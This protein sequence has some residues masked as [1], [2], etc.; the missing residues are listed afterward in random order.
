MSTSDENLRLSW[1]EPARDWVE[2]MP[3]GNGRIGAMV[4]G[5]AG[6][7]RIRV[8]DSTVWSGRPGDPARALDA[9][10]AAGAGPERLDAVRSAIDAEDYRE[11][12]ALL[13]SFEGP[14]SQ[15]FLPFVDL[16]LSLSSAGEGSSY[17]R[18]L[19][20]L[21]DAVVEE[22]FTV[23]N[24]HVTRRTWVSAPARA[25]CVE[26]SAT[27]AAFDATLALDSVLRV[28]SRTFSRTGLTVGIDIPVD[29]APLHESGVAEPLIYA[30]DA[31]PSDFDP[32]A[33]AH[34]AFKTDGTVRPDGDSILLMGATRLLVTLSTASRAELW[35]ADAPAAD[36]SGTSRAEI[37]RRAAD[38]AE[39][40][41]RLGADALFAGHRADF[42]ALA[43]G[44]RIEIGSNRA[45]TWDVARDVLRGGDDAFT[46]TVM[47]EFG[48]YLLASSSRPGNPPANLQG[49]WNDQLRPPWSSN[50]TININTQMNYWA[51]EAAGLAECHLP[52]AELLGKL[53]VSGAQV[54][55]KLYGTRGWVAHHNTDLWAWALPVGMGHSDPSWAI[56]MMGGVWLSH[57]LW[58][59]Y[60]FTRDE[61]YLR[62]VAWPILAG[63]AEFC[64]DWLTTDAAAGTLRTIPSTSP[65]NLFVGPDGHAESLGI[66]TAMDIALIRS[67]FERCRAAIST[68]GLETG[69]DAE[70]KTAITLLPGPQVTADGRLR[71]WGA[72]HT[73]VDPHHRHMSPMVSLYP[74]DL[75]TPARTPDLADAAAR[76]L[77]A[78]GP[79][80]MG[81]SWAWKIALR[82]RL[83]DGETARQLFLEASRPYERDFTALAP[84]DGSEWGG[85]LPNLFSTHP[86]FQIDG[87]YGFTAAI[88]EML[89]QSHGG[90]ISLL[91]ALPVAWPAGRAIGLG[92]RGGLAVDLEWANGVLVETTLR[93][94]SNADAG[95]LVR[96]GTAES[97]I[98]V[99][100]A[101]QVTIT[102][103]D[104]ELR[105][106][107]AQD[108]R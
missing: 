69:L 30:D 60:D 63:A 84:V 105:V 85:L 10:L 70:L 54:A 90:E 38:R 14:Y 21:D 33:A 78:R 22:S 19:L 76:F 66:S 47:A 5:G 9:V 97:L 72:E 107:E 27:G 88:I 102:M 58:E 93:N 24:A 81:W 1:S 73:E 79:G 103:L 28:A 95:V 89:L 74:L 39:A 61:R 96:C 8:N 53:S 40:A 80:A 48:R 59:H 4:F 50:Y 55:S 100:A 37:E 25:L 43:S 94:N 62:D 92:A 108:A 77:D 11:A 106:R 29:G 49:I 98:T 7:A 36:V 26:V 18:R 13:M 82:A 75:I 42:R 57:Q 64:L 67:L 45:G 17:D 52:L 32:F 23:G 12:E 83:G 51:A 3:I 41:A 104:G 16:E 101:G 31:H 86:P 56:W 20:D 15:E 44:T 34:L 68:L 71:E 35:W 91:P 87:N 46:A 99:P 6:N 65:E 2:A